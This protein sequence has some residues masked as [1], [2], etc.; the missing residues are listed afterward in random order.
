MAIDPQKQ[1]NSEEVDLGQLFQMVGNAFRSFFNFM[2][3]ILNGVFLAFIWLILFVKKN[4]ILL[5]VAGVVGFALGLIQDKVSAPVYKSETIIR[6]N[7]RTGETLNDLINYLNKLASE[8]DTIRLAANLNLSNEEASKLIGFEL[9]QLTTKNSQ[10]VSFVDYKKELDSL[11]ASELSFDDY[12]ENTKP[13]NSRDQILVVRSSNNQS[14]EK[15]MK[16]IIDR[17]EESSFFKNL[18][19]KELEELSRREAAI[20]E[21]LKSSDSLQKV[22]QR[23]LEKSV[24]PQEGAQTSVTIDN[25]QDK[26]VTKEY[27][28]YNKD[29]E[30]RRELVEIA[31]IKEDKEFIIEILGDLDKVGFKERGMRILEYNLPRPLVYGFISGLGILLIL[32]LRNFIVFIESYSSK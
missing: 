1:N 5:G 15:A 20:G 6:Q 28:L 26:S 17:L 10:V 14:Q 30:L 31:R 32:L 25:N 18:R 24:E 8:K 4:I 22:Y 11:T 19:R 12:L 7:Y 2:G 13:Y 3:R 9:E 16:A 21:A 23:V 29:L 27:E